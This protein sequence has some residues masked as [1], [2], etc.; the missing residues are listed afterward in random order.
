MNERL[1][2]LLKQKIYFKW[3]RSNMTEK[4]STK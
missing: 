4:M 2:L 3:M 1:I